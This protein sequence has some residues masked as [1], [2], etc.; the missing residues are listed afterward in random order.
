MSTSKRKKRRFRPALEALETRLAPSAV[1]APFVHVKNLAAGPLAGNAPGG[2]FSP[3]QVR[4]AYGFDQVLFNGSI[5]GDG[6]GQTIAIIDAYDQPN[7][8]S[9]LA[10]FD[11]AF[12][13]PAPPSFV[14]VNQNGG[15]SLP[16][17]D[18]NWGLEISLDVEWAHA[19]APGAKIL[20]VEANSNNFSDL[21]AAVDYARNQPGVS[22][23][24]MSFGG[25]EWSGETSYDFH[26][27]TPTGHA[28]V[29]FV[30]STGDSGSSGAPEYPSISPNVVGVG[31]TTLMLDGSNNYMTESGW[32][33]SGGGNSV[34]E[35]QPG[36]QKGVV[37]QSGTKRT[38]PDVAYDGS[39]GSTFGIFDSWG[40]GG[41]LQVY[42]TSAGAP[43]WAA[44]LAIA[45]QGR[46]LAGQ[47]PLDGVS[48][49][50]PKLY[51]LPG[52]DYHDVTSGSN[53]GYSAGAGYD[54]VTGRGTPLANLVIPALIDG[55]TSNPPPTVVT[56][57]SATPNPVTGTTSNL[58]VLGADN[59]GASTLTYTWSVTSAPAAAPAPS[60]TVNGS[61]AAQNST[62]TFHAAGSYTLLATITDQGGL[63][64]TS[65]VTVTVSQTLTSVAVSPANVSLLGGATQQF[66]A[67]ARDQF[68]NLMSPQPSYT[69]TLSGAGALSSSGLYTAPSSNGA[70]TVQ[71][72]A[73]GSSGTASVTVSMSPP[74]VVNPAA[75]TPNPVTGMTANLSVLGTDA[76]GASSLT[77][78]WSVTSAPAGA[79]PTFSLNGGNAAQNTSVTFRAAG[80]YTFQATIA[81]PAG[82]TATSSVTVLV[83]QTYSSLT[84]SPTSVSVSAGGTQQLVATALDQFGNPLASQ[85]ALNWSLSGVG[86]LTS[87]GLYTAPSATGTATASAAAGGLSTSASITVVPAAPTNVSATT[88]SSRQ[89]NLSW[90]EST[91]GISGFVIQRSTDAKNWSQIATVGPSVTT[92]Q[93]KSVGRNRSYYYRVAATSSQGN[94]PWSTTGLT[95]AVDIG[96][97]LSLVSDGPWD[98]SPTI[99]WPA[100]AN[101]DHYDLWIT[102]LS[103]GQVIRQ[104]DLTANSYT[105][106]T[107]LRPGPYMAWVRA[108]DSTGPL[109]DWSSGLR[110]TITAPAAPTM[111]GPADGTST[112][113]TFTWTA[114]DGATQYELWADDLTTGQ[115][116]VVHQTVT[117]TS[118]T[119][120]SPIPRGVYVVW[121]RAGNSDGVFGPWSTAYK[122]LIDTT[123]PAIPTITAPS[124][125]TSNLT[126]TITWSASS[127]AAYYDLWVDN[128]WTHQYQVIRQKNLTGN[129]FTPA[130]PLTVGSYVAWVAAFDSNNQTRGWSAPF[131]FTITPPSAPTQL[132]VSGATAGTTPT[133]SW[134]AVTGAVRYDLWVD[135]LTTGQVQVIRQ[136]NQSS[137]SFTAASP[138]PAGNYRFWVRAF[139]A[140]GDAG[141]W[142]SAVDFTVGATV[143]A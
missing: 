127:G 99:A 74:A 135:D 75:A 51:Q 83:N 5:V 107:P 27:T 22:V 78:T 35:S 123:A 136:R 141:T 82:W 29:T 33:G 121:V 70:A 61:N 4:H 67:T 69:W 140:N 17:A 36:Y 125:P 76:S 87:A 113:P 41:W 57:A 30:A 133:F 95:R 119:P 8:A 39:D 103:T 71:A 102:N 14:K 12:G 100:D 66:T 55:G 81:D 120:A 77:Y 138:L 93:D 94:S 32:S 1:A 54:L 11:A 139:N 97:G 53:G 19:I 122:F 85:P 34:Y 58:S 42:G 6:S 21:F 134:S 60:F 16:A 31:G 143:V 48:Q 124:S 50:L 26:F 98:T 7:I 142:S 18:Q 15:S 59:G 88:V 47:G 23:V 38:T 118:Y 72:S 25:S 105:P 2:G 84:L 44:L 130:A 10:A 20:L 96:G 40:Y 9:D 115:S 63:T 37:S 79:P 129:F 45:N 132:Q 80:A 52:A 111:T 110:F 131:R 46:A 116:Q 56:P 24:S 3:S 108:F 90:Q 92:Y 91:T 112:T 86:T 104:Q 65:S 137:N 117:T 73:G 64:A 43:Q 106:D 114:S 101:A 13:L 62:A 109:G 28:G 49:T 89:V 128:L 68:N 126:P